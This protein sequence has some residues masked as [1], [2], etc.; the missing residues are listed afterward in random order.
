MNRLQRAARRVGRA[1]DIPESTLD[2]ASRTTVVGRDRL[3]IE[4]CRGIT[5]LGGERLRLEL[6]EGSLA[7]YGA[8]LAIGGMNR[9]SVYI[10]GK[11]SSMEWE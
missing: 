3:F 1:L 6:S 10:T 9:H 11:I 7:V 2:N 5:E 4:N 8:E